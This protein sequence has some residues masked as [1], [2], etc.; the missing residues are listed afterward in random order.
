MEI[1]LFVFALLVGGTEYKGAQE[2]F[3]TKEACEV[4]RM[5]S[6]VQASSQVKYAFLI[7][8]CGNPTERAVFDIFFG[9]PT[10]PKGPAPKA[11]K[12]TT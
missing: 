5:R 3:A 8:N 6:I 10:K 7:S 12:I 2:T 9:D 11:P 4:V 1:T